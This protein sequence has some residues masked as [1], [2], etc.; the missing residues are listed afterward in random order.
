MGGSGLRGGPGDT[1]PAHHTKGSS[2]PFLVRGEGD[3]G[4][5]FLAD[6]SI[7]ASHQRSG[8]GTRELFS[9]SSGVVLD[10]RQQLRPQ[11]GLDL[12]QISMIC[13]SLVMVCKVWRR[14]CSCASTR[15]RF[16]GSLE[17][18]ELSDCGSCGS[19]PRHWVGWRKTGAP[20]RANERALPSFAKGLERGAST[21]GR[22]GAPDIGGG[23]VAGRRG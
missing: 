21:R 18:G 23:R 2:R 7:G 1:T 6:K 5:S 17:A 16:E 15:R 19:Q 8:S 3:L 4:S 10:R 13:T 12:W 14:V 20:A 9:L 11:M 22:R